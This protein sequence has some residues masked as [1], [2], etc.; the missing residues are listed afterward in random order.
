[1]TKTK[2]KKR[3]WLLN[4]FLVLLFIVGLA[5]IFNNQ[6]KDFL[7]QL[8]GDRYGISNLD[9][10]QLRKNE[11]A[12]ASFDFDAV[13]PASTEAVLRAQ[14]SNKRLPVIGGIAVPSVG[15]SLPIF[16]GL[17]NEALLYGAGTLAEDQKM[18]KGNYVLAS[19][20]ASR[21][22]LLFTPLENVEAG[23]I[24]YIT[25]L[26]KIYTYKVS[27]KVRVQPTQVEYIET[28]PGKKQI[29]LI[30]CGEMN[31]VTRIIVQ[32]DLKKTTPIKKATK[33]MKRAFEMEQKT[34]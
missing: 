31:G 16:K 11:N 22:D 32:G 8:N 21:K 23:N 14:L 20:R 13:E 24:V 29:T 4:S 34:F 10:D 5:L 2:K 1:M 3:N 33:K 25:D 9:E 12:N 30:T 15:I 17:S 7:I 19:H 28:T 18:G 6:I 27:L 26:K